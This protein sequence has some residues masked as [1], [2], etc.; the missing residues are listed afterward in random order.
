MGW[1]ISRA[2]ADGTSAWIR[3]RRFQLAVDT[4]S[5]SWL[6]RWPYAQMMLSKLAGRC[7]GQ[8]E[9]PSAKSSI[10]RTGWR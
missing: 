1:S 3:G 9:T 8:D 2:T 4:R 7:Y 6:A 5:M 10:K